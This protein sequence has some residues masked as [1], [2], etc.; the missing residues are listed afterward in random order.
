MALAP[1]IGPA[2]DNKSPTFKEVWLLLRN[3]NPE[4]FDMVIA[5]LQDYYDDLSFKVIQAPA[6]EVMVAQGRA[7]SAFAI[8]RMLKECTVEQKPRPLPFAKP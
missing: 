7:Q 8:L 6:E 4:A 2:L 1:G 5:R 3:G